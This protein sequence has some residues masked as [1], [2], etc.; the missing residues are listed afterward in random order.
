MGRRCVRSPHIS[1]ILALYILFRFL[2][3]KA[4]GGQ[5]GLKADF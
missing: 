1:V 2:G 5:H 4:F 3:L